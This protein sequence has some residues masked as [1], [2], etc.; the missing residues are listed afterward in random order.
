[1]YPTTECCIVLSLTPANSEEARSQ[2]NAY[3]ITRVSTETLGGLPG[4]LAYC[5]SRTWAVQWGV[6]IVAWGARG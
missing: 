2:I 6:F 4:M 3:F 5:F 1:M